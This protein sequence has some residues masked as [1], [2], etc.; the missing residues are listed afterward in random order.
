[1]PYTVGMSAEWLGETPPVRNT[2]QIRIA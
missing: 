2:K 1:M